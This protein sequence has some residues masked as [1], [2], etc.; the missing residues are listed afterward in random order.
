MTC[1][2]IIWELTRPTQICSTFRWCNSLVTI[3]LN[4]W[5]CPKKGATKSERNMR[6]FPT[7]IKRLAWV[8]CRCL[9]RHTLLAQKSLSFSTLKQK[10]NKP[11]HHFPRQKL[12]QKNCSKDAFHPSNFPS[13]NHFSRRN[14]ERASVEHLSAKWMVYEGKPY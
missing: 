6:L 13:D 3:H 7:K 2:D 12:K 10:R 11:P 1:A 5:E 9:F 4:M 8:I 14:S